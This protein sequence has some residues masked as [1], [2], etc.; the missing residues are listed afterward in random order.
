M[1]NLTITEFKI[2]DGSQKNDK[3]WGVKGNKSLL[4]SWSVILVIRQI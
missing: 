1:I 4:I 2:S 3:E